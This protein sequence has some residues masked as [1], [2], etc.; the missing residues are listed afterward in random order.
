[1]DTPFI[2]TAENSVTLET[3]SE[4]DGKNNKSPIVCGRLNNVTQF[5]MTTCAVNCY[6][7]WITGLSCP[8]GNKTSSR[9]PISQQYIASRE[10]LKRYNS[11][12]ITEMLQDREYVSALERFFGVPGIADRVYSPWCEPESHYINEKFPLE[13]KPETVKNLTASNHFDILLYDEMKDCKPDDNGAYNFPTWDAN[14]FERNE[15]IQM[16]YTKWA[17][18]NPPSANRLPS[19]HLRDKF[20]MDSK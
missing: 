6:I 5:Y 20:D 3:W 9:V 17:K 4:N 11:V 19:K 14:R 16:N 15:S 18:A 7:Q 2:P 1:M 8:L 12:I 13:M 10:K